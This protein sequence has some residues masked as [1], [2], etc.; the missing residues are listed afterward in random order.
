MIT[1]GGT[2]QYRTSSSVASQTS[3]SS[4][5]WSMIIRWTWIVGIDAG[6]VSNSFVHAQCLLSRPRP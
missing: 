2:A 4:G 1:L 6:T 5:D 3:T